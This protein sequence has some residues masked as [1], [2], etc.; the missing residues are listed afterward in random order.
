MVFNTE[1][2]AVERI[3]EGNTA[4][5]VDWCAENPATVRHPLRPRRPP[6]AMLEEGHHVP[7]PAHGGRRRLPLLLR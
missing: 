1:T 3:F 6:P 5:F 2:T 4:E 7:L